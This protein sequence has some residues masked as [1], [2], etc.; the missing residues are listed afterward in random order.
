MTTGV[1]TDGDLYDLLQELFGLGSWDPD[2]DVPWWKARQ[3]EVT[4]IKRSRTARNV[5]LEDLALAAR[6]A[7]AH[8]EQ[9]K[10]ITWLYKLI[11]PAIRWDNERRRAATLAEVDDLIAVAVE[12]E[13][14]K[15]ESAWLTQL[16]RARGPHRKVVYDQWLQAQGSAQS[17]RSDQ[18]GAGSPTA[19]SASRQRSLT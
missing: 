17:S 7:K 6:Y 3:H 18:P 1:R 14:E 8:G 4:K 11:T 19:S 2:S 5:D 15:P 10:A 13:A 12:I 16:V 9:V